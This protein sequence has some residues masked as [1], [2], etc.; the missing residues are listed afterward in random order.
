MNLG[1]EDEDGKTHDEVLN[2][3]EDQRGL[4]FSQNFGIVDLII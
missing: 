3:K 1:A 4:H 2:S